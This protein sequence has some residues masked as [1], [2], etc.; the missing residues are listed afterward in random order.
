MQC[1]GYELGAGTSDYDVVAFT[2]LFM[3]VMLN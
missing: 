1:E 2:N 3:A